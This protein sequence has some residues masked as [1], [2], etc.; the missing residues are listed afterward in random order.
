MLKNTLLLITSA[1]VLLPT[2]AMGAINIPWTVTKVPASGLTDITFPFSIA[3]SP[4]KSGYYFAQQ[5]SF[6][7]QTKFAYCGFQ[8]RPDNSNGNPV[9]HAVFSSFIDGTTTSDSNCSPGADGGPGVSCYVEFSGPYRDAYEITITK[10]SAT[11]WDGEVVD[12]TT[13]STV[14][15]I[16]SW[17]LPGGTGGIQGYQSGFVEY[18]LWKNCSLPHTAITFGVPITSSSGPGGTGSLGD[19]QHSGSCVGLVPYES[20]KNGDGSVEI[21]AGFNQ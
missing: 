5:F 19:A 13:G 6:H 1:A 14:A 8:P 21:S 17:T 7:G 2:L 18:Y 3:H 20:H 10:T 4:H 9:I 16:G 15:H 11:T 12:T